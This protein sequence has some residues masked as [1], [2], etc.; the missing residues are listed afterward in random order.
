[1]APFPNCQQ[2]AL[3]GQFRDLKSQDCLIASDAL[4]NTC[5]Q[6]KIITW[7]WHAGRFSLSN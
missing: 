6:R 1:L 7:H 4:P 3:V 5:F 2:E